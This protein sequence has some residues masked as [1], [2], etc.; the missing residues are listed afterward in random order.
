MRHSAVD[1][2]AEIRRRLEGGERW[3]LV[4]CSDMLNLAELR[5][6]APG[7]A[8]VPTALYF[9][10]N[11]L[12]YPVR[13]EKERDRHFAFS[14]FTSALA[15]DALWWNSAFH[16]DDFLAAAERWFQRLPSPR[17]TAYLEPLRQKSNVLPQGIEK[18]PPRGSRRSGPLRLLWAARW[19]FDKNPQG[20]FAAAETL[21]QSGREFRLHVLGERFKHSPAVFD[22]ARALLHD[23]ID[24]W[25]YAATRREYWQV[26][27]DSDVFVSTADHE[28]F[29][30]AAAEA[31]AAGCF[32]LLPDRLAYPDLLAALAPEPR[33]RHLYADH[34]DLVDRLGALADA[35][36][37]G[38]TFHWP[39][40]AQAQRSMAGYFW[41]EVCGRLDD[42]AAE[43]SAVAI[44]ATAR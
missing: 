23:H 36:G 22:R 1:F 42:A 27:A 11:Q 38:R 20:F 37:E 3:D 32:P 15:A 29:G 13:E 44:V 34:D 26:L 31:V 8:S 4:F 30:V 6:L 28:F 25:G 17:P 39:G 24:H 10:E 14:N 18:P 40:R 9:H 33:S 2:A 21:R 7:I 16:R 12:T 41:P 19:E 5:G 35:V 43:L